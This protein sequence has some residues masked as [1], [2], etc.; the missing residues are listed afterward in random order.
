MAKTTITLRGEQVLPRG[1]KETAA[2]ITQYGPAQPAY[3]VTFEAPLEVWA[4]LGVLVEP[5]G[6][7]DSPPKYAAWNLTA[8]RIRDAAVAVVR[9]NPRAES[10]HVD[11][12]GVE[13]ILASHKAAQAVESAKAAA[14]DAERAAQSARWDVEKAEKTARRTAFAAAIRALAP[15]FDVGDGALTRAAREG[16]DVTRDVLAGLARTLRDRVGAIVAHVLIESDPCGGTY[17]DAPRP[18]AKAFAVLDQIVE[19]AGSI[20]GS[21]PAAIGVWSLSR[22]A[23][24]N[25]D[26]INLR[27]GE[28]ASIVATLKTPEG[29]T[30][31]EITVTWFVEPSRS[32]SSRE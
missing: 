23:T 19:A 7:I 12:Q 30:E 31:E 29:A 26:A 25:L 11:A 1:N 20:N 28:Y 24:L 2:W 10:W 5:N 14:Y 17:D 15:S 16:Y 4:D 32:R 27:A 22:I 6:A 3:P 13:A 18:S 8:D 21:L 9:A